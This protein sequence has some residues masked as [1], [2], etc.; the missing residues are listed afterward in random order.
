M[1]VWLN[2][3]GCQPN[4]D[5]CVPQSCGQFWLQQSAASPV[6]WSVS[7]LSPRSLWF[8]DWFVRTACPYPRVFLFTT[9][10]DLFYDRKEV[11]KVQGLMLSWWSIL[12][13]YG[14]AFSQAML[15]M[16]YR[17][18]LSEHWYTD[19]GVVSRQSFA[20]ELHYVITM[21]G[22]VL[23]YKKIINWLGTD[24]LPKGIRLHGRW[25]PLGVN[26]FPTEVCMV[27]EQVEDPQDSPCTAMCIFPFLFSCSLAFVLFVSEPFSLLSSF[28]VVSA[29][30]L[31]LH[32][33]AILIFPFVSVFV[34]A[35]G[36]PA[37][38]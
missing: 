34:S 9:L 35:G 3:W 14:I 22:E 29:C 15:S 32:V 25:K 11:W 24:V 31:L 2:M 21:A 6:G 17:Y 1:L 33:F 20:E 30:R 19:L 28:Y 23:L 37:H 18:A 36:L 16:R 12:L 5:E 38:S 13:I 10:V 4:V 27:A 8:W 26:Y 7:Q